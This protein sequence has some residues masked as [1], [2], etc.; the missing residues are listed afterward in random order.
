MRVFAGSGD[1][2]SNTSPNGSMKF[3]RRL[4]GGVFG[5][6]L[7]VLCDQVVQLRNRLDASSDRAAP[8]PGK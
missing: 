8:V 4:A 7:I 1:K 2:G 5:N 6:V 3:H